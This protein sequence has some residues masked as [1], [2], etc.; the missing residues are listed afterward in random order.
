MNVLSKLTG[1]FSRSGGKGKSSLQEN[2]EK[3]L[4]MKQEAGG[5]TRIPP[6]QTAHEGLQPAHHP[7]PRPAQSPSP[8]TPPATGWSAPGTG[9]TASH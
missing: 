3:A 8:R 5:N 1:W 7:P 6:H 9:P 2:M 4:A